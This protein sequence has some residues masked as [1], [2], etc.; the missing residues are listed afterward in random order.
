MTRTLY[1]TPLSPFCR[2]IRVQMHEKNLDFVLVEEPVWERRE[3]FFRLNP[4]GEVPVLQEENKI[5]VSGSYAIGEYIEEA[6]PNHLPAFIGTPND[7]KQRAEVRRIMTWF[8]VKFYQEVT[9]CILFEKVFRSLMRCGQPDSDTIRVGKRNILYHMDYIA[10]LTRDR[11]WLAG[12]HFSLADI[13]A[14]SHL[15]ALDYL[16]DVPWDHA[17]RA[18]EWYALIKSRPS[19]RPLLAERVRGFRPPDWYD[20]PD[21]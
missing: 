2:K 16:G 21:F 18:K 11:P 6:Y 7:L 14:A 3:D 20:N 1:H 10:H 4:A 9:Q 19:F 17:P 8:D 5:V 15:S 13:A 12:E